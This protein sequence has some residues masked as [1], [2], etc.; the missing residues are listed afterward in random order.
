MSSRVDA[1]TH[2][3]IVEKYDSLMHGGI[4][5]LHFTDGLPGKVIRIRAKGRVGKENHYLKLSAEDF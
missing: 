5:N 4:C 2:K 1:A 3:C